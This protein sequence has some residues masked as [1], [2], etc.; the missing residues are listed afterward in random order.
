MHVRRGRLPVGC[1]ADARTTSLEPPT[2][3]VLLRH[4]ETRLSVEKRFSGPTS[5]PLTARGQAMAAAAALRLASRTSPVEAIV[6]SPVARAVATAAPVSKALGLDVVIEDGLRE[7]DFGD[8][9]GY[10]FAEVQAKWPTEMAA[11]LGDPDVAP[12]HGDSM[13]ACG[14]R[15]RQ[16]RDRILAA[17][18]GRTVLVVSHVTPIKTLVRLALDAPGLGDVPD[19]PRPGR[20][21]RDRLVRRRSGHVALVQRDVPPRRARG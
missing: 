10:S 4:G 13:A 1:R 7:M 19:A 2:T 21:L 9:D 17:H 16:A 3:L 14:R 18:P 15:V 5:E 11:W 8:W 6:C 12:P 20:D